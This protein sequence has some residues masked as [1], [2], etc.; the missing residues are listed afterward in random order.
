LR[1][2]ASPAR[3]NV[4]Q[5]T[6]TFRGALEARAHGVRFGLRRWRHPR[7]LITATTNSLHAEALHKRSRHCA[8]E[9]PAQRAPAQVSSHP[10]FIT[11]SRTA[12]RG[13]GRLP[14]GLWSSFAPP[15]EPE[16]QGSACSPRQ[17]GPHPLPTGPTSPGGTGR[18]QIV[19]ARPLAVT[20]LRQRRRGPPA[21]R[22]FRC[23]RIGVDEVQPSARTQTAARGWDGWGSMGASHG[24]GS[25]YRG[26]PASRTALFTAQPFGFC[27]S[28]ASNNSCRPGK[29]QAGGGHAASSAGLAPPDQIAGIHGRIEGSHS[30]QESRHRQPLGACP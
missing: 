24:G 25:D 21:R 3:Q 20:A 23:G 7:S 30:R 4:R 15:S 27:S 8:A 26:W 5:S 1:T 29:I 12:P 13:P 11:A 28:L 18:P 17:R 6:R 16:C 19:P 2:V 14:G 9:I 10:G 22:F